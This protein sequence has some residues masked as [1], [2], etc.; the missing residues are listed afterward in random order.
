MVSR[1]ATTEAISGLQYVLLKCGGHAAS[2]Q[3]QLSRNLRKEG[4]QTKAAIKVHEYQWRCDNQ[5]SKMSPTSAEGHNEDW[6]RIALYTA[7]LQHTY[8]CTQR[9]SHLLHD[10]VQGSDVFIQWNKGIQ[11]IR[12]EVA[13]RKVSQSRKKPSNS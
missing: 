5:M 6:K 11:E 10:T 9:I 1:P 7:S 12:V 8:A 13:L 3:C 4:R 2:S